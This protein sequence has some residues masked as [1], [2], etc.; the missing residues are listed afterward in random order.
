MKEDGLKVEQNKDG[1]FALEWDPNDPK[2]SWLNSMSED[3][4]SK[5]ISEHIRETVSDY[6]ITDDSL[7][8]DP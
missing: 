8:P 3:E 4:I 2:W 7:T 1:T 5:A 6:L